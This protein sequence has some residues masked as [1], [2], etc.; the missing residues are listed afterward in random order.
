MRQR[1]LTE[2]T[3]DV[4]NH[5]H[6]GF[7]SS[8]EVMDLL[9]DL[10]R[11]I[12]ADRTRAKE[13]GPTEDEPAFYDAVAA[14]PSALEPGQ[15]VLAETAHKLWELVRKDVTVDWR[16]RGQARDRIRDE[17]KLLLRLYGYPPDQDLRSLR[18][19]RLPGRLHQVDTGP[20]HG[21][22]EQREPPAM[23]RCVPTP[24]LRR[25]ENLPQVM[26]I[27]A[28]GSGAA[29]PVSAAAAL[30]RTGL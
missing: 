5:H 8:A 1:T 13:L 12:S 14:N 25:T 6:N 2:K 4:M 11:T 10:A 18:R 27:T 15:G 28:G 26:R 29:D 23:P 17:V 20:R 3:Q 7:L 21:E 30:S 22:P 9:V 24:R 19:L 16:V